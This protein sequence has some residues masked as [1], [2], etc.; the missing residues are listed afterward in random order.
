M[1]NQECFLPFAYELEK[2]M[3]FLCVLRLYIGGSKNAFTVAPITVC[4]V[5][6]SFPSMLEIN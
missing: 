2:M 4:Y 3:A 1:A 5:S 6:S